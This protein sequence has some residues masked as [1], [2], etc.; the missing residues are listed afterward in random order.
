MAVIT[1]KENYI[2]EWFI[3]DSYFNNLYPLQIQKLADL[4]WTPL[5]VAKSAAGFLVPEDGAK[6]LDI[7]SGAGK[8]CLAASYYKPNGLFYG[9]E[10]R[11]NLLDCAIEAEYNLDLNNLSFMHGNFTQLDFTQFDHF[12][13]YNSFYENIEGTEKIDYKIQHSLSLYKYYNSYLFNQLERMPV[14]T[15]VVTYHSCED[16]MPP[17]YFIVETE[18]DKLLKF[19]MKAFIQTDYFLGVFISS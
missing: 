5:K 17:G 9:I 10:Q 15:R 2:N 18:F 11:K 12:Y 4:H 13:F 3:D 1:Q 7:G 8:F 16:Y 14:G 19:W 6:V